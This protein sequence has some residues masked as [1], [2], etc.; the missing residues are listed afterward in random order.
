MTEDGELS[1]SEMDKLFSK[2][3]VQSRILCDF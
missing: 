1:Q 3:E 2:I